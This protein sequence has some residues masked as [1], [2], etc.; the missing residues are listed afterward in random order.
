MARQVF[1]SM[2]YKQRRG[3]N[4]PGPFLDFGMHQDFVY[5]AGPLDLLQSFPHGKGRAPTSSSWDHAHFPKT[6]RTYW[7]CVCSPPPAVRGPWCIVLFLFPFLGT[8]RTPILARVGGSPPADAPQLRR[9]G[10]SSTPKH[11]GTQRWL[12]ALSP[13]ARRW[14]WGGAGGGSTGCW[15]V[16]SPLDVVGEKGLEEEEIT[17]KLV[18]VLLLT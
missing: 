1:I 3:A 2:I 17:I 18:L 12:A 14:S 8:C 4:W 16:R 10:H 11:G 13:L 15:V 5:N 9:R 7:I 6:A